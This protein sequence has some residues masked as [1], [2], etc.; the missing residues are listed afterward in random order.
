LS[1]CER[2][3][4]EVTVA[5]A[6]TEFLNVDIDLKSRMDPDPLIQALGSKILS[7]RIGKIGRAHWVRLTLAR[8]PTTP[9][10][11]ILRFAKLVTNLS[12]K[13]RSIWANA[14]SRELDIG[15]QGGFEPPNAEWVL[16]RNVMKAAAQ[17]GAQVRI[18]VY[19]ANLLQEGS[20]RVSKGSCCI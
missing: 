14:L 13:G 18:T 2:D 9:G 6:P 4:E 10:D 1:R 3:A 11:A 15:I 12:G 7:Q 5:K 20:D 8:Q 19:S 17:L 16:E